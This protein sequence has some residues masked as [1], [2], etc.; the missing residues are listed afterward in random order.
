[1]NPSIY[2]KF[3]D[4]SFIPAGLNPVEPNKPLRRRKPEKENSSLDLLLFV[5]EI[6][7]PST[8]QA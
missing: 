7:S 6:S 8:Q 2:H 3:L 1:M 4:I 5:R